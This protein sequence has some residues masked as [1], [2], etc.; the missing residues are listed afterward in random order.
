MALRDLGRLF[1]K[2]TI[3]SGDK[4]LLESFLTDR[5]E[6]AFEEIVARHGPMVL[7]ACRRLL[8]NPHD[9]DDAFQATFLLL[10]RRAGQLRDADR[11]GP[12]LYG[13]AIRVAAKARAREARR[14][15]GLKAVSVDLASPSTPAFELHDIRPIL[16][17]ELS[18]LS[19]RH[20]D[21]LVLCLLEGLTAEEASQHLSCPLG[22]VKSRLARGREA[23]RGRLSSRGLAP[24]VALTVGASASRQALASPVSQALSLTTVKMACL[25]IERVPLAVVELTRG[26][27]TNMLHKTS[28]LAVLAG[29]SIA[30]CATG[31][32]AWQK[33]HGART[34]GGQEGREDPRRAREKAMAINHVKLIMLAMHNYQDAKK[35]FPPRAI[36]GADSK[37]KLSW[38]V[39]LLPYLDQQALYQEF[40]LDEAWDSP[41]NKALISRMPDVFTT[42]NSPAGEGMTRIRVF[43]GPDTMFSGAGGMKIEDIAD[44]TSCTV[45]I[46]AAREAVPWT[47]PGDLPYEPRKPLPALD[48]DESAGVLVGMA[49]GSARFVPR[50][51]EALWRTLITAAGAEPLIWPDE[52]QRALTPTERPPGVELHPTPAA[53][54]PTQV[55]INTA[56]NP[57]ISPE[58]DARLRAIEAKLDRLLRKIEGGEPGAPPP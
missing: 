43:E 46:V 23:L 40:R 26:V 57:N 10:V 14:R 44:G 12:W 33:P 28:I 37:P 2:G 32:F 22:T 30:L 8:G 18:K 42:P 4:A 1:R 45:A 11:L 48:A 51:N 34:I 47:R 15:R 25:A 13:V 56:P 49:D 7:G 54:P 6:T 29:G 50:E 3:P 41:H 19:T 9:A 55:T 35:S 53:Q 16:D 5:D 36:T 38:R 20:R 31:L 52:P 21:V 27:A 17:A 39:A 24:A 58:L